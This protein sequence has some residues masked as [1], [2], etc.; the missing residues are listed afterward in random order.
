MLE[1]ALAINERAYGRDHIEVAPA[2]FNLGNVHIALGD[3]AK[4]RE[5]I[6]RAL[7]IAEGAYGS[8]HPRTQ[9]CR[10]YL[11]SLATSSGGASL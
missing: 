11:A 9:I 8:D 3:N 1:R 4:A 6:A 2:L 7:A 10:D 5:Y